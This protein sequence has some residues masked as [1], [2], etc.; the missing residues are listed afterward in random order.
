MQYTMTDLVP[1]NRCSGNFIVEETSITEPKFSDVQRHVFLLTFM[2]RP[3]DTALE[4]SPKT[5]DRLSVDRT[6]NVLALGVVNGAVR[7][8]AA[9][10]LIAVG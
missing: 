1:F 8:F 4:D 7:R 3:D 6:D 10:M 5:L 2:E 9:E